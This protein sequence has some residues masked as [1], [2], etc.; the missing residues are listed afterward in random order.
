VYNTCYT[1]LEFSY[2]AA[3]LRQPLTRW[4]SAATQFLD[5]QF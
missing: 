2:I 3:V 4:L 5:H 1:R